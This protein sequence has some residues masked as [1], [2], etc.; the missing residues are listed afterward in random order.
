[1]LSRFAHGLRVAAVLVLVACGG[2]KLE[3]TYVAEETGPDGKLRSMELAF[4]GDGNVTA[5]VKLPSSDQTLMT[6]AGS[7]IQDGDKLT[8]TLPGDSTVYTVGRDT[9]TSQGRGRE[10]GAEEAAVA[11]PALRVECARASEGRRTPLDLPPIY[12][13]LLAR[14][15]LEILLDWTRDLPVLG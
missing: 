13:T 11:R 4:H 1:M 3:G 5:T 8:V 2:G 6:V 12:R 9:L 15:A 7:Y 14:S 10:G